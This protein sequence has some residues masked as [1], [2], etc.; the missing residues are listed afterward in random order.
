MQEHSSQPPKGEL[1]PDPNVRLAI[2]KVLLDTNKINEAKEQVLMLEGEHRAEAAAYVYGHALSEEN[3]MLLRE[4]LELIGDPEA[5]TNMIV[6]A[7]MVLLRCN[8]PIQKIR[9]CAR[10]IVDRDM[11]VRVEGLLEGGKEGRQKTLLELANELSGFIDRR[12]SPQS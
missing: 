11:H 5:H 2:I 8:A 3:F 6:R 10:L 9:E 1:P 7:L 12:S 4:S